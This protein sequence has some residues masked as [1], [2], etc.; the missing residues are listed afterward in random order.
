MSECISLQLDKD[1][2]RFTPDG[3]V[4][5]VDAIAALLGEQR[6]DGVW[7]Q[8]ESQLPGIEL[9]H[10]EHDFGGSTSFQVTDSQGWEIIESELF[11]YMMDPR[12]R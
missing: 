2:V 10:E 1:R 3:K 6:P 11:D 4:V 8:A 12:Q 7:K 5:V 9:S